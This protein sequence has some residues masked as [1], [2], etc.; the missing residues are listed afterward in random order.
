[1]RATL[2]DW[3]AAARVLEAGSLNVNGSPR[4]VCAGHYAT[5]LGIDLVPGP[6]V[7]AVLDVT[8]VGERFPEHFDVALSTEM[9][10]HVADWR[11]ALRALLGALRVGG[12]LVLTTRS[13]GF[14]YHPYPED[15]W[16]FT[17]AHMRRIFP[18]GDA[19]ALLRLAHD[20]DLRQGRPSGVGVVV[21]RLAADLGPWAAALAALTA[22]NVHTGGEA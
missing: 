4:D 2:A 17:A 6:G 16:R 8:R 1:V 21:R 22:Y 19:V 11:A 10:E 15:N 5:Y 9:L 3:P 12:L 18:P 14:E 7:D 20:P 13:P